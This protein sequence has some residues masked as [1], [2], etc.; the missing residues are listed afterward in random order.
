MECS[1]FGKAF[2]CKVA[3]RRHSTFQATKLRIFHL[4]YP[5]AGKIF[6]KRMFNSQPKSPS[7]PLH[8]TCLFP[9]CGKFTIFVA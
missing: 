4:I 9:M 7:N 2:F 5:H 3:P 6:V 1:K 8:A